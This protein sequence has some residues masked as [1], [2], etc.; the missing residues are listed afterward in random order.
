MRKIGYLLLA[1][2]LSALAGETS[3]VGA[4]MTFAPSFAGSAPITIT[5][6]SLSID[7][8]VNGK[9]TVVSDET[10]S[11][12]WLW[13]GPV[14]SLT[15]KVTG[16]GC[17]GPRDS[18]SVFRFD[19]PLENDPNNQFFLNFFPER[20]GKELVYGGGAIFHRVPKK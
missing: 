5:S 1:V 6:E 18:Y 17:D 11:K 14:R 7:T 12:H 20:R 2:N 10:T 9:Y 15:V 16:R 8:C 4:W 13:S 3:I 19:L